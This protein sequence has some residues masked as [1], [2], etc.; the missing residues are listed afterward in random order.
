MSRTHHFSKAFSQLISPTL[1]ICVSFLLLQAQLIFLSTAQAE[2]TKVGVS[3]TLT[4]EA[5]T[6]GEDMRNGILLAN[7]DLGEKYEL[8]VEDEKCL[9]KDSVLVA[10]KLINVDKVKYVVGF[11]CNQTVLSAG[12]VYQ[13]ARVLVISGFGTTGDVTGIGDRLFRLFPADN[14]AI[15]VIYPYI[16]ARHKNLGIITEQNEYPELLRRTFERHFRESSNGHSLHQESFQTGDTDLKP[17]LL[18]FKS[19][20]VEALYIA[21]NAEASF[22]RIVKQL[23]EIRYHPAIFSAFYPGIEIVQKTVGKLIDGM[24]FVDLPTDENLYSKMASKY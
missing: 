23:N 2:R 14:Y 17:A 7:K 13:R 24:V 16:A 9:G 1:F 6:F 22:I 18:R 5:A 8:I 21:S 20:G 15:D 10:Q 19:K 11:S 4:G 3:V 12:P